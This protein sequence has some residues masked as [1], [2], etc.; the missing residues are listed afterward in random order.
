[1]FYEQKSERSLCA[2]KTVVIIQSL[3]MR[4]RKTYF[5]KKNGQRGNDEITPMLNQCEHSSSYIL[6]SI[7]ST[8]TGI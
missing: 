8:C 5:G 6:K 4:S 2:K 3:L 7:K 1:M